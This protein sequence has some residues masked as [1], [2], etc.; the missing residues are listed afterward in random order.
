VTEPFASGLRAELLDAANRQRTR[1]ARRRRVST[2]SGI[3]IAAAI[4]IFAGTSV[5]RSDRASAGVDIKVE[6]GHLIVRLVDLESRPDVIRDALARAG[7]QATVTA[8]PVGPSDVGRFL[9]QVAGGPAAPPDLQT[10]DERNGTFIGFVLPVGWP[11][12]LD[13]VVARPAAPAETYFVPSNAFA[14]G[15][16]LA[17]SPLPGE[18]LTN[19]AAHPP[20][21]ITLR[22]RAIANGQLDPIVGLAEAVA[23]HPTYRVA[24]ANAFSTTDVV[25]TVTPDGTPPVTLQTTA[26]ARC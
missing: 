9:G 25:L 8:K 24:G 3:G 2:M 11:G 21:G 7:L 14:E 16:P 18:T 12:Q 1:R 23:A 26:N 20:P 4:L 19:V 13:L 10:I 5:F 15:E 6:N 22:V 17:C